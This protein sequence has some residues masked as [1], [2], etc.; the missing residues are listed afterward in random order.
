MIHKITQWTTT[1]GTQFSLKSWSWW[2]VLL[3]VGLLRVIEPTADTP[4]H[5]LFTDEGWKLTDA[6]SYAL[7]G[8]WSTDLH[9]PCYLYLH[10]IYTL[11]HT[12][13]FKIF[14]ISFIS[15]RLL[16]AGIGVLTVWLIMRLMKSIYGYRAGIL[17]GVLVGVNYYFTMLQRTAVIE[18]V[19]I[20]I[21]VT[22]S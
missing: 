2:G 20:L 22:L 1:W 11:L 10:P 5:R 4:I 8:S 18:P 19:V 3:F 15:A 21:M 6:R 12:L 17:A 13:N 9:P 7:F 14:G 16:T